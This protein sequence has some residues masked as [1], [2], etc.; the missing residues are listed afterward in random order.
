VTRARR[1]GGVA[2]GGHVEQNE[3]V[4]ER[5]RDDREAT[6]RD[7]TRFDQ[8]CATCSHDVVHGVLATHLPSVDTTPSGA[9][10]VVPVN[11]LLGYAVAAPDGQ[12]Q[13]APAVDWLMR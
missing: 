4:P 6:D 10:V 2:T 12:Q 1:V 9:I 13:F 7:L 8:D 11:T 5:V 3:R